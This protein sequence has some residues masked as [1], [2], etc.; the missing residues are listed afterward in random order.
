MADKTKRRIGWSVLSVTLTV[1]G[2]GGVRSDLAGWWTVLGFVDT[3][4][5]QWVLVGLGVGVFGLFV[6]VPSARDAWSDRHPAV[7]AEPPPKEPQPRDSTKDYSAT[8]THEVIGEGRYRYLLSALHDVGNGWDQGVEM[9][10]ERPSGTIARVQG[11]QGLDSPQMR[12]SVGEGAG[13]RAES[14]GTYVIRWRNMPLPD[15]ESEVIAEEAIIL[16]PT[17][18]REGWIAHH[19][20]L[21]GEI[22]FQVDRDSPARGLLHGFKCEIWGPSPLAPFQADDRVR[23]KV[24]GTLPS[25][26]GQG[27]FTFPQDFSDAPALRDLQD[28]DYT[29]Y[30]TAW[31]ATSQPNSSRPLDVAR[32][33][34]HV[35]RAGYVE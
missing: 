14:E 19:A 17:A 18:P 10:V 33:A 29:V 13:I 16:E 6:V 1:V 3:M 20:N 30:W 35:T 32:D 5:A 9:Q 23:E 34:F 11:W 24:L 15:Y 8:L 27:T 2:L 7:P 4:T 31:E 28:G 25:A 22:M 12:R 26:K 21:G